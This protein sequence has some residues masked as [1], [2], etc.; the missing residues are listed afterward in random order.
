M[1][2]LREIAFVVVLVGV[3]GGGDLMRRGFCAPR[4]GPINAC[5]IHPFCAGLRRSDSEGVGSPLRRS[6]Q[7]GVNLRFHVRLF[8]E[9]HRIVCFELSRNEWSTQADNPTSADH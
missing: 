6:A 5:K 3:V 8:G 2:L 1:V 4:R 9:E 7:K